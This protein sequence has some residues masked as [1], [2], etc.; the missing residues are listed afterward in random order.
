[1]VKIEK[2]HNDIDNKKDV[3]DGKKNDAGRRSDVELIKEL[4]SQLK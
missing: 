3:R 4:K 2:T 1:M